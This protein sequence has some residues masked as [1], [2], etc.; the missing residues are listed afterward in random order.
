MQWRTPSCTNYLSNGKVAVANV[1]RH[2]H[3]GL[4]RM[5]KQRFSAL[6]FGIRFSSINLKLKNSLRKPSLYSF[7]NVI[8]ECPGKRK[9]WPLTRNSEPQYYPVSPKEVITAYRLWPFRNI[10]IMAR[11]ATMFPVF[12]QL[13]RD[14]APPKN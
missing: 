1:F 9:K 8:S 2:G 10:P 4:F 11:L 13:H 12:L 14:L 3:A 7:T 5:S 6:R